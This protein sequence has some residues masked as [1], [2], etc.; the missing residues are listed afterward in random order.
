MSGTLAAL[1]PL[2]LRHLQM[3]FLGTVLPALVGR[4]GPTARQAGEVGI[5]QS[6]GQV[7]GA[8][9]KAEETNLPPIAWVIAWRVLRAPIQFPAC[10]N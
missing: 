4:Q 2:L 5:R 3:N 1:V 10:S 6:A 9:C 8:D 7:M